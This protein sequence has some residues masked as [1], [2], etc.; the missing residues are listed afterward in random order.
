MK[1]FIVRK[2][3]MRIPHPTS[4]C[5]VWG[6]IV[7][8]GHPMKPIWIRVENGQDAKASY[9]ADV[10]AH[11][12]AIEA[13]LVTDTGYA[14]WTTDGPAWIESFVEGEKWTLIHCAIDR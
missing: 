14:R 5:M 7:E 4:D 8:Y 2:R 1:E 3:R 6:V 9:D 11:Q 10:K 13:G 12:L